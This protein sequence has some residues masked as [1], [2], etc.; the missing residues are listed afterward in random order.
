[1]AQLN[2]AP[3][4]KSV[5]NLN[6]TASQQSVLGKLLYRYYYYD[7]CL[8]MG[9]SEQMVFSGYPHN[10]GEHTLRVRGEKDEC[11]AFLQLFGESYPTTTIMC[12]MLIRQIQE[13]QTKVEPP[14]NWTRY[15][16]D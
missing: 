13:G 4:L 9:D 1:M 16:G 14:H 2:L 8:G 12:E 11:I 5:V 10:G 7:N 3:N 15:Q 6:L